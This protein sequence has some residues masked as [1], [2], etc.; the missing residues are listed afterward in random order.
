MNLFDLYAKIALDDGEY[1]DGID[2]VMKASK[3]VEAAVKKLSNPFENLQ[4]AISAVQHPIKTA[5]DAFEG[6]KSKAE[7]ARHPLETLKKSFNEHSAALE[8]QRNMLSS[9]ANRYENAK[10]TVKTLSAE[11]DKSVKESGKFSDESK[12]LAAQ[13]ES[14]Q[15]SALNAKD[16]MERYASGINNASLKTSEL[17]EKL[18]TG[19]TAAAKVGAAAVGAASAAFVALTKSSVDNYGE[20]EQLVGGVDTL[21]KRQSFDEFAEGE[22]ESGLSLAQ[23]R[24]EYEKLEQPADTVMKN[25]AN[26]FKTVGLSANEYMET[27]TSFSASL[28]QSLGGDTAKAAEKADLAITDMADNANKMGTSM[29]SVQNAYSGFSRGNYTMLDNLKLGYAGTKEEMERL[30]E[31]AQKLSG[32]EYDISSYADI[33]DAIHVVQTEMGIT[34]TTAKEA[35]TTIQGSVS[36][37][38]AAWSNFVTGLGDDNAD[39]TELSEQLIE[40]VVTVADNAIPVIETVLKNIAIA[41]QGYA[42][43]MIEKFVGYAIDKLPDVFK[44]G[45]QMISA[46]VKGFA[47]NFPQ[48]VSSALEIAEII[49]ETFVDAIPD[50]VEVGKD[51]VRGLWEGIKSMAG[52]VGDKIGGFFGGVIDGAKD[53]LGIHSPSRVFAGIGE[54]MA[55]GLGEGW[56]NEFSTVKNDITGGLD[57]GVSSVDPVRSSG[58]SGQGLGSIQEIIINFTNEMDGAALSRKQYKYNV[59]ENNLRGGS[60]VEVSG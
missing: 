21:F 49:A 37:M 50:I 19:L 23:L 54:N 9:L 22:K 30:L 43:E 5:Q 53:L 35:A 38:K 27:V 12:K 29:E 31:D 18:K 58:T 13:L 14:A 45:L 52:W 39:I 26:A 15:G 16:A 59:R 2:Q 46:L 4:K 55:L 7:A 36:S 28:L 1:L 41:V 57:F 47:E 6:L 17:S 24:E 8:R 60:L 25:A 51:I 40:S 42:P 34:G 32:I 11:Y 3:N 10:D 33:V 56:T 20:Y 44:L 48:I